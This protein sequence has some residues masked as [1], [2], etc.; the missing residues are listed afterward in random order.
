MIL[1]FI[2]EN[3]KNLVLYLNAILLVSFL[4]VVFIDTS[5]FFEKIIF[6]ERELYTDL[7]LI[8]NNFIDFLANRNPY[9]FDSNFWPK[10]SM[11]PFIL[12]LFSFIGNI[13]FKYIL[14]YFVVLEISSIILLFYYSYK[15]F[16]LSEIKYFY[17]IIY[18]FS[19]N[20]SNGSSLMFGNDAS[21]LYS[22]IGIGIIFLYKEKI[23]IF[24]FLVFI[25]CLFKFHYF[26]FYF[27]PFLLYGWKSLKYIFP[28]II[29]IFLINVFSYI[30][31]PELYNSYMD[32]IKIQTSRSPYNPWVGS[33]ITQSF[34]SLISLIGRYLNLDLYPSSFIS[35]FFWFSLTSLSLFS[36]FFIY[37]QKK[38]LNKETKLNVLSLGIL[39]IFLFYPRLIFYDFFLIVPA[40]YYLVQKI[41]FFENKN[42]NIITKFILLLF[43]LVVQDTH[44]SICSLSM[45]FFLITYLE[46]KNKDPL[47]IIS[48]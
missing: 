42:K 17:P 15:L 48:N 46:Y 20:F 43:F 41:T 3:K 6:G 12:Q 29:L 35:N 13:E 39:T 18:F 47:S 40:Y 22:L 38:F 44:A 31:D 8:H 10:G 1:N 5:Y 28:F 34:A 36:I 9:E 16:P 2:G 32:Y 21:I 19:F 23:L 45:L 30:S 14:N 33:D 27:L 37:N 4:W 11:P 25:A 7:K 26:L 24:M